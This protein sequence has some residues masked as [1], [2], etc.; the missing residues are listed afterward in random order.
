MRHVP[1]D[2]YTIAWF[3]LA[4]CVARGEREKA[5]GVYRLLAHSL[6]DQAYAYLLEGDLLRT[7]DDP[8]AVEKYQQAAVLYYQDKRWY[9]AAGIF[10]HLKVLQGITPIHYEMMIDIH[11]RFNDH[12]YTLTLLHDVA[13]I[14]LEQERYE[15]ITQCFE[16]AVTVASPELVQALRP[17]FLKA[18][19]RAVAPALF[20]TWLQYYVPFLIDSPELTVF[21]GELAARNKTYHM[22]AQQLLEERDQASEC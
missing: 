5:Y 9:E 17:F 18:V 13:C 7:F 11:T 2:K 15:E 21:M 10:E 14:Y 12:G 3:K 4:E 16:K 6:A 1:T 20:K 22:I 8:R 19:D